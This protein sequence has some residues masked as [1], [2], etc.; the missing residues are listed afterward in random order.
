MPASLVRGAL[1]QKHST[2]LQLVIDWMMEEDSGETVVYEFGAREMRRLLEEVPATSQIRITD[3]PDDARAIIVEI[4]SEHSGPNARM[5]IM[6]GAW[7][8]EPAAK[9]PAKRNRWTMGDDAYT[10]AS[11][12]AQAERQKTIAA[13]TIR[14]TLFAQ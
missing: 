6:D 12:K 14:V 4:R 13:K 5:K 1:E 11:T 10:A 7:Y 2:M 3:N 9:F 8:K